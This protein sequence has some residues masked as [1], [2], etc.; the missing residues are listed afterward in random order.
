MEVSGIG[1]AW[2]FPDDKVVTDL[3]LDSSAIDAL[4]AEVTRRFGVNLSEGLSEM[5]VR[6][7]VDQIK[8]SLEK[9]VV[10]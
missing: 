6:D 9:S 2:I 10:A 8:W 1:P 7:L 5:S 4:C 3:S